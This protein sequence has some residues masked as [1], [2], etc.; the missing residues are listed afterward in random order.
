MRSLERNARQKIRRMDSEVA[1]TRM[2]MMIC[3]YEV[4]DA[5]I[6]EDL[7]FSALSNEFYVVLVETCC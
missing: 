1:I 2:R 6:H 5:K 4:L 7:R 3:N